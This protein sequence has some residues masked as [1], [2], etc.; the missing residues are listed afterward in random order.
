MP[1]RPNR[2]ADAITAALL[3]LAVFAAAYAALLV[4]GALLGLSLGVRAP[5]IAF[6]VAIVV[7]LGRARA[8]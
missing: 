5:A 1:R 2:L 6:F 8:R 7:T 3:A 4:I